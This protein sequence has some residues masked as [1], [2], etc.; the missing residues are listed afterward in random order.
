[1]TCVSRAVAASLT[2]CEM[3]CDRVA[4]GIDDGMN[5]GDRTFGAAGGGDFRLRM[6]M[7]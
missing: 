3:K 1:M 7:A 2:S 4:Q 5:L 6:L